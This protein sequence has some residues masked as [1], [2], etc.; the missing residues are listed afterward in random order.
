MQMDCSHRAFEDLR[1]P[2]VKVQYLIKSKLPRVGYQLMINNDWIC[3]DDNKNLQLYVNKR[4]NDPNEKRI[5]YI[6]LTIC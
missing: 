5:S 6:S 4:Q 1:A 2:V 3:F